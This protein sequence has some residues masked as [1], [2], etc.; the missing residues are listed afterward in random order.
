VI[1]RSSS[2]VTRQKATCRWACGAVPSPSR[3]RATNASRARTISDFGTGSA[4]VLLYLDMPLSA[5]FAREP[6][7]EP[8]PS[9]RRIENLEHLLGVRPVAVEAVLQF[10]ASASTV[11][12]ETNIEFRQKIGIEAPG[13]RDLPGK[14]QADGWLPSHH[15]APLAFAAVLAALEPSPASLRLSLIG[16][17]LML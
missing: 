5:R 14:P 9:L 8:A 16:D 10:D 7:Q 11:G 13:L 15:L 6:I 3:M 4:L 1:A 12:D 17:L 2:P